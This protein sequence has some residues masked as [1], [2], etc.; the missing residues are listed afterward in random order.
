MRTFR[1]EQICSQVVNMHCHSTSLRIACCI[2]KNA[3]IAALI[4]VTG[5][6]ISSSC[7][8]GRFG[9][10]KLLS[11]TAGFGVRD[12]AIYGSYAVCPTVEG[13]AVFELISGD[14]AVFKSELTL[15]IPLSLNLGGH[16]RPIFLGSLA[17]VPNWDDGLWV[18]DMADPTLPVI[19]NQIATPGRLRAIAVLNSY[20]YAVSTTP[21][22][23][24]M[25]FDIS[26]PRNP[27]VINAH[28]FPMTGVDITIAFGHA[29]VAGFTLH[30]FSLANP[31]QPVLT[32][33]NREPHRI[34]S[35]R[36]VGNRLYV[37]DVDDGGL[38][39]LGIFSLADPSVPE[40]LGS[41]ANPH[42]NDGDLWVWQDRAYMAGQ[43]GLHI[44]DVSDPEA[45]ELLTEYDLSSC[46]GGPCGEANG[47]AVRGSWA[48]LVVPAQGLLA[49]RIINRADCNGDD[50]VNAS[51]VVWLAR[52]IFKSGPEPVELVQGD[53]NCDG[54]STASDLITQVNY[55]FK[56]AAPP[57]CP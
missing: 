5:T 3:A 46:E 45:P 44:L 51:D 31:T 57:F 7:F 47:I 1:E 48:Y 43:N 6:T 13:L 36:V 26:D 17:Y 30:T 11:E 14:S 9:T 53:V 20:A 2:L 35:L 52:Y 55:I 15:G 27:I 56:G 12:M 39:G 54:S 23:G 29:Y 22:T 34:Q 50:V 40:F 37:A 24:I 10:P 8:A 25:T 16:F 4:S 42:A 19:V 28:S 41:V 18:I 21:D 38:G 49:Y 33:I 32:H